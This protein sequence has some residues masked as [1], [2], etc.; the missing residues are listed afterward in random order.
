MS[1]ESH[2]EKELVG[3]AAADRGTGADEVVH[4]LGSALADAFGGDALLAEAAGEFAL[5]TEVGFNQA[6][7]AEPGAGFAVL[8]RGVAGGH[9]LDG[10]IEHP[11]G[12]RQRKLAR[13]DADPRGDGVAAGDEVE[14][15]KLGAG[16]DPA[17]HDAA[18][19]RGEA[20]GVQGDR[21]FHTGLLQSRQEDAVEEVE[22]RRERVMGA[23]FEFQGG[24]SG[25]LPQRGQQGLEEQ[26]GA[27]GGAD[28]EVVVARLHLPGAEDQLGRADL[29]TVGGAAGD[30][31]GRFHAGQVL[32][33]QSRPRALAADVRHA[34]GLAGD[35]RQRQGRAQHLPAA[36]GAVEL[37]GFHR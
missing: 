21:G 27:A 25:G 37:E 3:E 34:E 2:R 14:R 32:A 20:G 17:F 24:R 29:R 16:F 1:G 12:E 23:T 18:T 6:A 9:D 8:D 26:A 33:H 5:L 15:E 4:R 36:G 30:F 28:G 10:G 13:Q 7:Q 31:A 22:G 35:H 19:R 11:A